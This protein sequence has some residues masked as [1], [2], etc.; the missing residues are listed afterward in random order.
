MIAAKDN[1]FEALQ[2]YFGFDAFKGPQEDIIRSLLN[3]TDTF[4]IM[5]TGGG[6]S[7]C[8]QLPALMMEGT[9][10]VISPLIALMKNQ[11][12]SI[13]SYSENDNVAHFLNSS[14]SRTQMKK[15]KSDIVDGHTK[16]LY[17]APETLTKEENL[18]FFANCNVSFVAVD[19]AHCI[20]EWGHDF[21]P[22][23]RRIRTMIDAIGREIPIIALTATATPKVRTD[24]VKTLRM[25][26]PNEFVSSFNR[27]NLYYE[28]RPKGKRDD[29]VKSIIQYIKTQP[30]KSGIIYVQARKSS[31]D[32]AKLLEVNGIKAAPYHAGLDAKTR[33]DT[34]D[35]FL[36]EDLEVIVATIAFGM[37]IDKPNVRFVIHY[38]IPKSIE[39]YY[40]ET[41][42]AGRDGL[43]G[44]CL[45]YY[46]YSD[47]SKLEKFLRDKPVSER[48]MGMQLLNEVM[49]YSETSA[50][51]RKYL[52]HYFGEEYDASRCNCMCDNCR[53]PKE[54]VE[55]G[56]EMRQVLMAID[57][58]KENFGF[59][60]I[61]EFILG[62]E[63]KQLLD[64]R[65]DKLP[66]FGIGRDK[67]ELFWN[68]V[69]RQALL[70]DLAYKDIESYGLIKLTDQ[71]REF[72]KKPQPFQITLNHNFVQE[73]IDDEEEAAGKITV[74]DDV[75]FEHLR[76]LCRKVAKKMNVPPY[77]V[78][79][80][81]SLIDM[82]TQY[83]I[84]LEDLEKVSGVNKGK[85]QRYGK[86]FVEYI[87]KYVE[88][89]EI[90]RPMDFVVKSIANKSKSKVQIIQSIDKKIPFEDIARSQDMSMDEFME[91]LY[92]IVSS[93]TKL[94]ID[95]FIE[96]NVDE[97]I[98]DTICD[99]FMEAETDDLEA[100][101]QE[102]KEEDI[103]WEEV[104][105]M[106]IK[107]LSDHAN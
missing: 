92:G 33:S 5:P 8:Y 103:T 28:V 42:R 81:P 99:Y 48:E 7:L 65:Y 104:R 75:L 66:I 101:F 73:L 13:R 21:R 40:Q 96:E 1:I 39:N 56:K 107:F 76:D 50:C 10:L 20:S 49:G 2:K 44:D 19:E 71:G 105:Y 84:T 86:P 78:F 46:S 90:E 88:E 82:A 62:K 29:T 45:A 68:S 64:Y 77:V 100:A 102:L 24:I 25:I 27:D 91:E 16:L 53:Y 54:K 18:E 52:L 61:V 72:I 9:A 6:K 83:P 47:L 32:I 12:D 69:M 35:A 34:Q 87:A 89:N 97:S 94:R 11:V 70:N 63:T 31:E 67:D 4:V 57:E 30:Q 14:L 58:L 95:Y 51:R 3:G 23:Y 37:G 38:D 41:G 85:A 79:S 55:V 17:V 93:G 43:Q 59:K 80:E 26:E 98:R 106:R 74:L 60:I 22:E 36:M 15:V